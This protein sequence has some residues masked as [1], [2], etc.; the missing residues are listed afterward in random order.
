MADCNGG[1]DF[2]HC[3]VADRIGTVASEIM[4]R[5]R[6]YGELPAE[7][8]PEREKGR[9]TRVLQL[10]EHALNELRADLGPPNRW[11]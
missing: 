6:L 9:L 4:R 11:M 7:T 10:L 5:A 2:D 1:D 3:G 8:I